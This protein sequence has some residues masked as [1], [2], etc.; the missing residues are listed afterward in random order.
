[1]TAPPRVD[2][3]EEI[4]YPDSDGQPMSDN[5][6][7]FRY[8]V[9]VKEGY[10]V[11]YVDDPEVFVAGD[12]LWYPVEFHNEIRTAPDALLAFGRPK[13]DRGSYQQWREGGVAPQVVWEVL[14]PGN[15][16]AQL[17]EKF[18]FY[19][20]YGVE[21]YYQ[22][23]P[24]RGRLRGWV[25]NGDVLE[26]IEVVQG[27]VSPRTGV[28]MELVGNDLVLTDPHGNPF[29]TMAEH[30]RLREEAERRAEQ[31]RQRAEQERQR[32]EQERQQRVAA[33]TLAAEQRQ[34]AYEE[35]DQR[36]A[37]EALAE[38]HRQWAEQAQREGAA[39]EQRAEEE[40]LRAEQQLRQAEQERQ[41]RTAA[42][43][44]AERLAARLRELGINP[45]E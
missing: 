25:R 21:E 18:L 39:A 28:R 42:E 32:A 44:R 15:Y 14:S 43:Q 31:E 3:A 24:D 2:P 36:A 40:R 38:E 11:L 22:Y 35:R 20:R 34:R 41:Q 30:N 29:R 16:P 4:V 45:D 12:L 10:E 26:E 17:Q 13:G 23:D 33:E 27:W 6:R 7:Q 5:T 8:I 9:Y 19:Q 37:A 1:M